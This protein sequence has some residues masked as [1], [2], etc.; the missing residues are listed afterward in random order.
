[1]AAD[2][3]PLPVVIPP[4]GQSRSVLAPDSPNIVYRLAP[5]G[6]VLVGADTETWIVTVWADPDPHPSDWL[7]ACMM[8][9]DMHAQPLGE[10]V[11]IDEFDV[12]TVHADLGNC[13]YP[14]ISA[15]A[16]EFI[17]A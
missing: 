5:N 12:W 17:A 7:D 2:T 11:F 3:S 4:P 8:L 13:M 6:T 1:M 10:P 15:M 16:R 14:M 9:R